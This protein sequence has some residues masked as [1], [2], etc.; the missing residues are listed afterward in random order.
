MR[1]IF[2]VLLSSFLFGFNLY[3]NYECKAVEVSIKDGNKMINMLN[4][5]YLTDGMEGS[6]NN[7]Y[8]INMWF[9]PKMM[10]L[11]MGVLEILNYR[12]TLKDLDFYNSS[13]FSVVVDNENNF[14]TI[15]NKKDN[16]IIYYECR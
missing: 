11:N 13:N 2:I 5:P 1:F 15:D 10:F 4:E 12:F 7:M 8:K 3:Q 6:L 9:M 16:I 14:L